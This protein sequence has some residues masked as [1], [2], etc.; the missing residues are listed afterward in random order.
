LTF[1]KVLIFIGFQYVTE[2]L[3]LREE[4]LKLIE[5]SRKAPPPV[6][7]VKPLTSYTLV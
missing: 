4:R 2:A 3:Q 1:L 7:P 5:A 6:N